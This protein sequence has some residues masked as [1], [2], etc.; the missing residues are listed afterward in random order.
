MDVEE[1]VKEKI[2]LEEENKKLTKSI[3]LVQTEL[4]FR[5]KQFDKANEKLKEIIKIAGG[6]TKFTF[7][8]KFRKWKPHLD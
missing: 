7:L 8:K 5:D 2:R 3:D 6:A 1:L 4:R